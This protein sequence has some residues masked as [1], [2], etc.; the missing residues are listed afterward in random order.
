MF[1][2]CCQD[3]LKIKKVRKK[4]V[5]RCNSV[6]VKTM[7]ILQNFRITLPFSFGS[8]KLSSHPTCFLYMR[9]DYCGTYNGSKS[10]SHMTYAFLFYFKIF[11]Q[12]AF[13]YTVNLFKPYLFQSSNDTGGSVGLRQP[14]RSIFEPEEDLNYFDKSMRL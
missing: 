1:L 10:K 8:W 13:I 14:T 6:A 7:K 3:C 12:F 5:S 4:R 9:V 2:H 11:M